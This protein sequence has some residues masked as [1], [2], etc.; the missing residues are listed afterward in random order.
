MRFRRF[1]D[2][3]DDLQE[4]VAC[5]PQDGK[6]GCTALAQLGEADEGRY[7]GNSARYV[8]EGGGRGAATGAFDSLIWSRIRA[9]HDIFWRLSLRT[10][11]TIAPA[12]GFFR[13]STGGRAI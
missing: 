6:S 12:S 9:V 2:G 8:V 4:R 3:Q 5:R 10:G 13:C 7:F 11:A 1:R